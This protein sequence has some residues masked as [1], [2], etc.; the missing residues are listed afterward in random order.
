MDIVVFGVGDSEYGGICG[1]NAVFKP[2]RLMSDDEI[3][4]V[5]EHQQTNDFVIEKC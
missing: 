4:F 3:P 2:K 1:G 5:H